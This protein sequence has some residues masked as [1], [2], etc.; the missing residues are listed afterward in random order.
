AFQQA[1]G[2]AGALPV[3]AFKTLSPGAQDFLRSE[4]VGY[5]EDGGSLYLSSP[6]LYIFLDKP[7]SKQAARSQR[8]L[9]SGRRSQ[10]VLALLRHPADWHGVK[11]LAETAFASTATVSQ[12]LIELEKREWVGSR[13]TGPHK[14]RRLLEPRNLLDAW[15]KHVVD[16]SKPQ[17]RRFFVPALKS[18]ELLQR[19]HQVCD[20]RHIA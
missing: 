4:N 11:E 8:S 19:V 17:S 7:P 6:D 9:F 16:L 1:E 2:V 3:I 18:E 15:V 5:Y 14:E 20:P 10:V 13:G 12:V